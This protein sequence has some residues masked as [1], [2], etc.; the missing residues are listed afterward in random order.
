[1]I[2]QKGLALEKRGHFEKGEGQCLRKLEAIGRVSI[3]VKFKIYVI[4]LL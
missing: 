1:M 3:R 2:Y 4:E